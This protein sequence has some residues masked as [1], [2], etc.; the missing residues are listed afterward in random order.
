M[1]GKGKDGKGKAGK[2][3]KKGQG[4]SGVAPEP[5]GKFFAGSIKSVNME[6]GFGFINCAEVTE[7]GHGQDIFFLPFLAPGKGVGDIVV[8]ELMLNGR[9]QPQAGKIHD[10]AG[11]EQGM[12]LEAIMEGPELA[13]TVERV[14]AAGAE[15]AAKRAKVAGIQD[16][17]PFAEWSG[18]P[19][20]LSIS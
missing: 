10:A 17:D 12:S 5:T 19:D 1:G 9:G 18:V 20:D 11:L 16:A 7:L 3:S 8:F 15:P 2:E 4:R 6:R 14:T 13:Q